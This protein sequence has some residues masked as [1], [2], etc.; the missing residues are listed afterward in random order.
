[1]RRHLVAAMAIAAFPAAAL[2]AEPPRAINLDGDPEP[3]AIVDRDVTCYRDGRQQPPP[4]GQDEAREAQ[5][6]IVDSCAGAAQTFD[7]FRMTRNT[8]TKARV[9]EADGDPSRPELLVDGRSGATGRIGEVALVRLDGGGATCAKPRF[10]FRHPGL[11]T[12]T[13]KPH[14]AKYAATGFVTVR[15]FR[16]RYAGQEL[17]LDQ[18]WYR[19]SDFGCCPSWISS[20]YYRYSRGN[21]RYVPYR[22]KIRRQ[23]R[24]R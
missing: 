1:M 19:A 12:R 3:E 11:R 23:P 6:T 17:R 15:D 5:V 20:R 16:K 9:L 8:V 24:P 22:S 13:R 18:P 7:L 2:A 4:C 21:D 10:L 14:G